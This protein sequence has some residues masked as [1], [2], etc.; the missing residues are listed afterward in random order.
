MARISVIVPTFQRP[1]VLVHALESL[2]A[3]T[4][5]DVEAVV[6]NDGGRSVEDVVSA[7]RGR[8]TVQLITLPQNAGLPTAR[9]VGLDHATGDLVAFLDDD[10]VFLPHHL[11]ACVDTMARTGAD[12]V[13]GGCAVSE[14]RISPGEQ[15][16][17]AGPFATFNYAFRREMLR[18]LNF[19]PVIGVVAR[20]MYSA[21]IRFDPG[22]PVLEDWDM[23]LQL[24]EI[25]HFRFA[26]AGQ[27]TAIYHRIPGS[28]SMTTPG[29]NAAV[30]QTTYEQIVLRR[31]IEDQRERRELRAAMREH[32]AEA[33][34][35]A[36]TGEAIDFYHYERFVS[37]L[38]NECHANV[39]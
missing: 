13:Y 36:N 34:Q 3:Q 19:I 7:F 11:A 30:F 10:D 38:F 27:V 23:W 31:A 2:A 35:K 4:Y 17:N 16:V 8:L 6:V 24:S 39:S 21:G 29:R 20:N 1:D 28:G 33:C 22:L 15:P 25:H 37:R 32:L 14:R 18:V 9:N 12:F 5:K 26:A